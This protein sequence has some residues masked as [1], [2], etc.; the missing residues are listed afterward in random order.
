MPSTLDHLE[1]GNLIA[2]AMLMQLSSNLQAIPSEVYGVEVIS[3][4]V[5]D[6][7]LYMV[8]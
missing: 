2:K 3:S 8:E 4:D 7:L 5:F 1:L 6:Y